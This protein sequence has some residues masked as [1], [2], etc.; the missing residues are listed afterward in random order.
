VK[1]ASLR[2]RAQ[3]ARTTTHRYDY[4]GPYVADLGNVVD[5]DAI[6]GSGV[7]SA[8]IRWA[9]AAYYWQPI[10]ERYGSTAT[11][12]NPTRSTRRSAS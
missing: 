3:I 4:I 6:R 8:S 12:V 5:M 7:A 1:R 9:A 11:V 2:A 10:A